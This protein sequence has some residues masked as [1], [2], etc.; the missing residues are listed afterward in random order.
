MPFV[1]T[2]ATTLCSVLLTQGAL[3]AAEDKKFT[4]ED[5]Q[6][7]C[8]RAAKYLV[9]QQWATG[10]VQEGGRRDRKHDP[11]HPPRN[12]VA[13]TSLAIMGLAAIGH[14]PTDPTDEGKALRAA[15]DFVIRPEHIDK[16]GY[17]GRADNSR[18]YGH[19]ITTLMLTEMLGMGV[20]DDMD[21]RLRD[22]TKRAVDLIIRS[23]KV[24]ERRGHNRGGWRYTPDSNDSDLS[25]TVWQLMALR[26]AKN[27]G[28]EVPKKVIDDAIDYVKRTFREDRG[29]FAYTVGG[30][31]LFS[32]IAE[33]LL[34]MQVCGQYEAEEV[35]KASDHLLKRD[36][37]K[38]HQWF[39]YGMYYYAQGMA[40]RGGEHAS[41]AKQTTSRVLLKLQGGDGSWRPRGGNENEGGKVYATSMALLSLSIHHNYL[42]I[43]Q[44]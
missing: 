15:L 18:M 3:R 8:D 6:E 22:A 36:P 5:V 40:Q 11:R 38:E 37:E 32:T 34:S 41:T 27:A 10:C 16:E 14:T 20:D 13:M 2:I 4:A 1:K 33:G 24:R 31:V 25:V 9:S 23:Q 29:G 19:G 35:I 28:I 30:H 44:R 43:Y 12:S 26:A 42:P 17:F 7:A 21:R 39:Y